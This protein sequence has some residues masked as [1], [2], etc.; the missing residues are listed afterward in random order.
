MLVGCGGGGDGG[1]G[2]TPTVN[3]TVSGSAIKGP[4]ANAT[5]MAFSINATGTKGGVIGTGQTDGQGNFSISVCDHSGPVFVEMTGGHYMDEAT[6]N[7]MN[8]FQGDRMTCAIH[9]MQSGSILDGIQIT[10]LTSIAQSMAQSMP[11]G[12]N[13]TNITEANSTVGQYFDVNDILYTHPMD[14]LVDGSGTGANQDMMNYGMTIAA[15]SQ[16]A[17]MVEMPHSSGMVTSMMNDASDGIMDGMMGSSLIM[18]GD[19]MMGGMIM[20]H[21]AGTSGLADAMMDFIQS[22]MN[23]SGV[24]LQE[25]EALMNKLNTSNGIINQ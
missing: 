17:D 14:P 5:I 16:Y 9:F 21:D 11:G 23:R 13:E 10:P 25:M 4:V 19:G 12:M 24:T 2:L 7:D 3:E 8:M 15:M 20:P 22:P 1:D 18:M 6:G